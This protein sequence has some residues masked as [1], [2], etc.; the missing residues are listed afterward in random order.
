MPGPTPA[1]NAMLVCD[2][3]IRDAISGK[4]S[5]I[6]IFERVWA[7]SFPTRLPRVS[8]YAKITDAQGEYQFRLA[9]VR[10]DSNEEIGSNTTPPVS[11]PDRLAP[12]DL[13][14]ELHDLVL[15]AEGRYEFR[16]YADDQFVGQKSFEVM[17][18]PSEGGQ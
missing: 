12:Y 10:L 2:Q 3:V 6:G 1:L 5:L 4:F 18:V 16:L 11:I 9:L 8:I 13:V 7:Q 17:R 15:P 14:F